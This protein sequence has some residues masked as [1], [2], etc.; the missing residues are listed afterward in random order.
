MDLAEVSHL[1]IRRWGPQVAG[2][3]VPRRCVELL[4]VS[5]H[6]HVF[7]VCRGYVS[8]EGDEVY[9]RWTPVLLAAPPRLPLYFLLSQATARP[10]EGGAEHDGE[11]EPQYAQED[12][13]RERAE[14]EEN[15]DGD[16]CKTEDNR[17]YYQFD[18]ITHDT[19]LSFKSIFFLNVAVSWI[20]QCFIGLLQ[21]FL[22]DFMRG[23]CESH[24][25]S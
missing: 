9:G 10:A 12:P 18:I 3:A 24:I 15:G 14:G 19:I 7:A 8:R 2:S 22:I 21:H 20:S 13:W 11:A 16:V 17:S 25:P 4:A 6:P 1:I 5:R 23:S